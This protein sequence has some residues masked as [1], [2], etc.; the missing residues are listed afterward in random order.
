MKKILSVILTLVI[1][2]GGTVLTPITDI[3][4]VAVNASAASGLDSSRINKLIDYQNYIVELNED[5]VY[6]I[7][8]ALD[9]YKIGTDFIWYSK[10]EVIVFEEIKDTMNAEYSLCGDYSE[11]SGIKSYIGEEIKILNSVT[12]P[13]QLTVSN[14]LNTLSKINEALI[15]ISDYFISINTMLES[16]ISHGYSST[17]IVTF[18]ANGGS[19]SPSSLSVASGGTVTLPTP[20][21]SGYKCLGWAASKTASK[22][23]YKCG[24]TYKVIS[25][26]TLYAVWE[27]DSGTNPGTDPET[28]PDTGLISY[29][30]S[31]LNSLWNSLYKL[32]A[33]SVSSVLNS[34]S[35]DISGDAAAKI[36]NVLVSFDNLVK[37]FIRIFTELLNEVMIITTNK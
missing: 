6:Y 32:L 16:L 27:A 10:Q 9:A 3:N 2:L 5:S 17:Y 15:N 30:S 25:D 35:A 26:I 13:T 19:V 23:D 12:I 29:I 28:R 34:F 24:G 1:L 33:S 18:N 14:W 37:E 11:L 31:T 4:S 7:E 8:M 20:T 21:R 36:N 22:A